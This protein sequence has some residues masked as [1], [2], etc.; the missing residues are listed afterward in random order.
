MITPNFV[1]DSKQPSLRSAFPARTRT[2]RK[3]ALSQASL[4]VGVRCV[5][6]VMGLIIMCGLLGVM[7]LMWTTPVPLAFSP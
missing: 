5:L 2:A 1:L 3:T 6:G 7:E 4:L